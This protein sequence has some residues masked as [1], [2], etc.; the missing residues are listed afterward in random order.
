MK[1]STYF[2]FLKD[3]YHFHVDS[4]KLKP[5]GAVCI[6]THRC[7]SK[8]GMCTYWKSSQPELSTEQ[9]EKVFDNLISGGFTFLSLSGGEPLLRADIFELAAHI[10]MKGIDSLKLVTNGTLVNEKNVTEISKYFDRAAV[11]LDGSD[12]EAYKKIRGID[13]FEKAVNSIKL[14]KPLLKEVHVSTVLQK[15]NLADIEN[16]LDLAKKLGVKVYLGAAISSGIEGFGNNEN[17]DIASYA[18]EIKQVLEKVMHHPVVANKEILEYNFFNKGTKVCYNP[19]QGIAV[20]VDANVYPCC[21]IPAPVGNLLKNNFSEIFENYASLRTLTSK[22]E[23]PSCRDCFN[24]SGDL[25]Y[26]LL[27]LISKY[28]ENVF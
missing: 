2:S 18:A 19:S 13:G 16:I 27:Y 3:I 28:S 5:N 11:S 1:S 10:K 12:S 22:L 8:C 24:A 15:D 25:R 21:I 26:D 17:P 6:L 7:N 23:H 20:G 4:T 9:W 14:M